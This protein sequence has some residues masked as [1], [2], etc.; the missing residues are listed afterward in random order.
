MNLLAKSIL[1]SAAVMFITA[2]TEKTD[3]EQSKAAKVSPLYPPWGV[4]LKARDLKTTP[5]DDFHQYANGKWLSENPVPAERTSCGVSALIRERAE[6]R[7]R[8]I[9]SD[10]SQAESLADGP[11]QKV[12]D[13]FTSWM[14][15]KTLDQLGL[16]PLSE[17]LER[18]ALISSVDDLA[19]EFGR[20]Y[21]V[22]G[23]SP[24]S[25][26]IG[27]NPLNPDEYNLSIGLSGL[28]LRDRDYYLE[29]SERMIQ[30][31][32]EYKDYIAQI[33][34][35]ADYNKTTD[36]PTRI[37][38]IE[39]QI[40]ELQW[41]R[42]DRRDRDKTFN[43]TLTSQLV[44][45]QP[46]FPW[47]R[48]LKARG[49]HAIEEINLSH[50][51][52][53]APLIEHIRTAEIED[54][55]AY[56]TFHIIDHQTNLLSTEIDQ[57][58]F[59]FWGKIIRGQ[60]E[61]LARWK[62]G[63]A[64]VGNKYGLGELLGQAYVNRHFSAESKAAMETLVE[65]LRSAFRARIEKIDWMGSTT[66]QE[67]LLKLEAFRAKIG[68]PDQWKDL[69]A[70][71][72]DAKTLF[73]N[74]HRINS[75]FEQYDIDRLDAKTDREE[76]FMMPQTVNAYYNSGFNEI[77]FPAAILDPPYFDPGADLAVNYGAIGAVIGHEMGHGFDDQG[78]KSDSLGVKRNWW[79]DRDR[80]NFDRR[81]RELINQFNTYGPAENNFID[82]EFTLGENIGDLGG[83]EV[84]YYA[85]KQALNCKTAPVIDDLTGDQ[86]FFLAFAQSWRTHRSPDLALQLLKIDPH[87]PPKY[88]VNGIVRNVD[89][90]YAAF[91]VKPGHA[92]YLD[93]SERVSIW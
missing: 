13:Y 26:W 84:A 90:W 19:D 41:V 2:C 61:P 55:R 71:S 12:G 17:D 7:V 29:D 62:R 42:S 91:D 56:L 77:V 24:F 28:G 74:V 18:I 54:W 5:G 67:A 60:S 16:S 45:E 49:I 43:P 11:E 21:F 32:S 33:L 9:I 69:S 3:S 81:T 75:F 20:Q 57:A 8:Q 68:Y 58:S 78:S 40:A 73:A 39:T 92:L 38:A 34:S 1:V 64:L 66:K 63:V 76:W 6:D 65:N 25:A 31:R 82:G 23:I 83:I 37:L 52:T 35:F 46:N 27:L 10:L 53:I 85:Y 47:N 15:T 79:T 86:R 88:R 80:A 51:D 4:D 59:E 36:W 89:A 44:A 50:P 72:I 48:F 87:S 30:I 22:N 14:D 70:I 93:K